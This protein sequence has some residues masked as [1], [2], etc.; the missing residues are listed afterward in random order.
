ML[1]E[2]APPGATC[3]QRGTLLQQRRW[4][5]A[6]LAR[7][8][9]RRTLGAP[10]A[11]LTCEQRSCVAAVLRLHRTALDACLVKHGLHHVA[12]DLRRAPAA[13]K[14]VDKHQEAARAARLP[15]R[16]RADALLPLVSTP[17][18]AVSSTS[19]T[20]GRG[21]RSGCTLER[22]SYIQRP[23]RSKRSHQHYHTLG[24]GNKACSTDST[25]E[26]LNGLHQ[27]GSS[28]WGPGSPTWRGNQAAG[29]ADPRRKVH[30]T[31]RCS[32][33]PGNRHMPVTGGSR[34]ADSTSLKGTA[35]AGRKAG[36]GS[37]GR[38]HWA[39]GQHSAGYCPGCCHPCLR[40]PD[41]QAHNRALQHTHH[42]RCGCWEC[43]SARCHM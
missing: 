13:A 4:R 31:R 16:R 19:C 23:S 18:D 14:G 17:S 29:L 33:V 24:P 39:A 11:L 2:A 8:R 32:R 28:A 20:S 10:A 9:P 40:K 36:M 37:E 43:S 21:A 25:R 42:V 26:H 6:A 34:S 5:C 12:P 1:V 30:T 41:A 35:G 22:R 7:T 38:Q 3:P 27:R 15:R